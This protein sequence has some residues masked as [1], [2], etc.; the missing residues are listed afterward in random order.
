MI[1]RASERMAE[2]AGRVKGSTWSQVE[3]SKQI[4]RTIEDVRG[5]VTHLNTVVREQY[6][7][8]AKVLEAIAAVRKVSVVNTDK[9]I[10]ADNAAEELTV[11]NKAL[12]ESVR[13]F[14]LKR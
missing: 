10:E 11:L 2:I 13:R 9:A 3:F 1:N 6:R 12:V 8:T 4:T 14:R 5:L 7:N